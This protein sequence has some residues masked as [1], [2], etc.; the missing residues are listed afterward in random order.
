MRMSH[1]AY[2]IPILAVAASDLGGAPHGLEVYGPI[3]VM[4]IYLLYREE[5]TRKDAREEREAYHS[6]NAKMREELR[7][8]VHQVRNLNRN[9]LFMASTHAPEGVREL[10]AKELN[11]VNSQDSQAT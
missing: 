11:R 1:L 7:S 8:L 2:F 3:G 4:C 10:A 6:E 5:K 9:I